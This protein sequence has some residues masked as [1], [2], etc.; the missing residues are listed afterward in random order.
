MTDHGHSHPSMGS[1]L[2]MEKIYNFLSEILT[3][4]TT[5]LSDFNTLNVELD[6]KSLCTL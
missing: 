5:S 2:T 4:L 3:H 1:A 6:V